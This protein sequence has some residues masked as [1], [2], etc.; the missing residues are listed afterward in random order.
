[1]PFIFYD[2]NPRKTVWPP[3]CPLSLLTK[4]LPG[5][6]GYTKD[7]GWACVIQCEHPFDIIDFKVITHN[8]T[9]DVFTLRA[10]DWGFEFEFFV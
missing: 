4:W 6:Q 9:F 7:N 1:M 5:H 3:T 2:D 10:R 8:L